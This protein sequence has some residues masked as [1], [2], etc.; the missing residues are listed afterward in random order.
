MGEIERPALYPAQ[1]GIAYCI[2]YPKTGGYI[3]RKVGEMPLPKDWHA[4]QCE[5]EIRRT[6]SKANA[7][8]LYDETGELYFCGSL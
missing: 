6:F 8:R 3:R 7:F 4:Q 5:D 2:T 1:K